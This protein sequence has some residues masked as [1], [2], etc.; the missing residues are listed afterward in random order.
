MGS[1]SS[2]DRLHIQL[3]DGAKYIIDTGAAQTYVFKVTADPGRV[4][5]CFAP[6]SFP[7]V[8]LLDGAPFKNFCL[9][10]IPLSAN[11][12]AGEL[13]VTTTFANIFY[14]RPEQLA[15]IQAKEGENVVGII[16]LDILKQCDFLWVSKGVLLVPSPNEK[17]VI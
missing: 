16:G 8:G 12:D 9:H 10:T 2:S 4:D 6:R 15:A 13:N 7:Q 11:G 5:G 1:A 17:M 14:V 3:H